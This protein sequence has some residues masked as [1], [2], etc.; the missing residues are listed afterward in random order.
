[1]LALFLSKPGWDR[2][3]KREKNFRPEFC[4]YSTWARKFQK[5]KKQKNSRN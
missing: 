3:T 4:S 1:M 2:T 5:K